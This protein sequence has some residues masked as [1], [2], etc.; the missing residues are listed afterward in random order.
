MTA[1]RKLPDNCIESG[2]SYFWLDEDGIMVILNKPT[3]LQTRADAEE[4]ILVTRKVSAGTPR[5]LLIDITDIKSMSR[6]AREV[7][8]NEGAEGKVKAVA[9]IT[10]SAMGR[11][12]GNF[13]LG[14]NKPSV[15]T[16]LFNDAETAR[17]WLLAYV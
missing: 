17:K 13:F 9:L 15:P 5:P 10:R 7:Y 1:I 2:A 14:F 11:I 12:V 3:V 16:R 4:N 6:E 8:A